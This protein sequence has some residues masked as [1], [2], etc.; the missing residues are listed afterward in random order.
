MRE[1]SGLIDGYSKTFSSSLSLSLL[2][3]PLPTHHPGLRGEPAQR[4]QHPCAHEHERRGEQRARQCR[5]DRRMEDGAASGRGQH[6]EGSVDGRGRHLFDA[7]F[8]YARAWIWI[9][10]GMKQAEEQKEKS[11]EKSEKSIRRSFAHNR[12][13]TTTTREST[14]LS[15]SLSTP[16]RLFT[17]RRLTQKTVL[18][19]LF[20][21]RD[22][23]AKS[24]SGEAR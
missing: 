17:A 24:S 14:N 9:R 7:L 18:G 11:K 5:R 12:N 15:L 1:V 6:V 10:G 21:R 16:P 8:F 2:S 23:E 3:S 22:V 20:C 4:A 19:F 13:S